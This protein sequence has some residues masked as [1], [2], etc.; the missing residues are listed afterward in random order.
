M[1]GERLFFNGNGNKWLNKDFHKAGHKVAL[2]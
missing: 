1:K 2:Y